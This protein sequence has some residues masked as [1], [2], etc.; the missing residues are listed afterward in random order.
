V[1]LV[2][3]IAQCTQYKED[4]EVTKITFNFW[5]ELTQLITVEKHKHAK[6][7]C[8]HI[9]DGLVDVMIE[10]LHYPEG[11]DRNDIFQGDRVQRTNFEIF[12]TRWE[13]S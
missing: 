3:C 4:L 6:E 9:Y 7:V 2:E 5:F 10:H 11:N 8:R 13:M 1:Y 12:A